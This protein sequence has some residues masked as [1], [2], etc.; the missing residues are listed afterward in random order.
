MADEKKPDDRHKLMTVLVPAAGAAVVIILVAVILA[1]SDKTP[2]PSDKG[3]GKGGGGAPEATPTTIRD[4]LT[5][6]SDGS[7]PTAADPNLKDGQEGLKYRDLKEGTGDPVPP[8]A[9]VKVHYTGWLTN[10]TRFD[11][12]VERREPAE[13]P[14]GK[15]VRGWTL[16]IPGMKVGGVRKLVIPSA[17][18]YGPGGNPPKIPGGATLIFEVELLAIK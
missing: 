17:L 3:K 11:S 9:V 18:G 13:F 10:G 14:L 8:G 5:K 7:D 4:D 16:G 15:V 6:L 1:L 2:D 12:S